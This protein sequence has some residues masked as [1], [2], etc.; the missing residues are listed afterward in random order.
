MGPAW[1]SG[2]RNLRGLGKSSR[3]AAQ[4]GA[5]TGGE[6]IGE[7]KP[8][9]DGGWSFWDCN[10]LLSCMASASLHL[11][12]AFVASSSAHAFRLKVSIVSAR[13]HEINK[14]R[15]FPLS[16]LCLALKFLLMPWLWSQVISIQQLYDD[17]HGTHR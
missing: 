11:V 8:A 9:R 1:E 16:L 12:G 10:A 3:R 13:S 14:N 17:D 6:E 4:G 2:S 7:G 15:L 5:S